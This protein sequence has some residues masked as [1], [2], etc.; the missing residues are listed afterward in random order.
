M[1]TIELTNDQRA[2]ALALLEMGVMFEPGIEEE[3][4]DFIAWYIAGFGRLT[5]EQRDRLISSL[6]AFPEARHSPNLLQVAAAAADAIGL[7]PTV[8]V[9]AV[10]VPDQAVY[11]PNK[12]FA[13]LKEFFEAPADESEEVTPKP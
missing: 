8:R 3:T 12:V 13:E 10:E 1:T 11:D 7:V 5:T 2:K 9:V 6:S 4:G